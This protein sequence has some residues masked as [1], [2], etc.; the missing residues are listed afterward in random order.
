MRAIDYARH[1]AEVRTI[2]DTYRRGAPIRVPMILGI[3]PRYTTFDHPANPRAT[4]FEQYFTDPEVMLT[5]QLEHQSWVRR[6]VPQD[7]E[8]GP[9]ES[10]WEAYVDFQNSYEAGWFGCQIRYFDDEAPDTL[11][12][13]QREEDKNGI[14]D[15][16]V[17]DPFAGGLMQRNWDFFEYFKN[18]QR[19]GFTWEG[20]PIADVRP[21]GMGTD[22]PLTVACNLRGASELYTDL[23]TDP[24][25]A[26]RLLEFITEATIARIQAYWERLELPP[27]VQGYGFADDA[28]QSISIPMYR[29]RVLPFH[30]RLV[31][32]L[33]A[34][35]PHA[36]HLCGDA[37]R[38][39]PL[40]RD[41]LEVYS[42]DTGFP[43]DFGSV[44]QQV[45]PQVEIKGGPAVTSLQ[46]AN[47][48]QIREE[49]RNILAS[50]IATGGRFILREANNLS[51]GISLEN[52]WAMYDAVKEFGRYEEGVLCS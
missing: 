16:G 2:W 23:A 47:P 22:G 34:G 11:P 31:E 29:E 8:M 35:G 21:A 38:Y 12:L 27:K 44:R 52:L 28:I 50:G 14:F 26:S 1:N 20:K 45:G 18:R 49:V 51:P 25:Y 41:E 42:F 32:A 13:L 17:P 19:D 15:A 9:P 7:V 37:A 33:S 6:H 24:D 48:A 39:F 10:G 4:T 5:R 40:L 30:R 43:I 36:I 3:N 46:T